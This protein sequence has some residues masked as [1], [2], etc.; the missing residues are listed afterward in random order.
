MDIDFA[1]HCD[2]AEKAGKVSAPG[3]GFD[4]IYAAELPKRDHRPRAVA[5]FSDQET[6]AGRQPVQSDI[7]AADGGE[8]VRIKGAIEIPG[9]NTRVETAKNPILNLDDPEIGRR[10]PHLV[11]I[12]LEGIGI[13]RIGFNVL[14]PPAEGRS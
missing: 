1:F 12:P 2:P 5:R 11:H 7:I 10:G 13:K 3:I 9:P 14:E 6:E 8:P 4:T